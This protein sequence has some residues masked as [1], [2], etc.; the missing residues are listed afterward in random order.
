MKMAEGRRKR[1]DKEQ[2]KGDKLKE[3]VDKLLQRDQLDND[4]A[5]AGDKPTAR[6]RA[7]KKTVGK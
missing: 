1:S 2:V 6:K 3:V 7:G 5:H 4:K